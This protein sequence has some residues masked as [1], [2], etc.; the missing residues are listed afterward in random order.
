M[1]LVSVSDNGDT[2]EDRIGCCNLNLDSFSGGEHSG[3]E[4]RERLEKQTN[5][6]SNR[7]TAAADA[8]CELIAL[9]PKCHKFRYVDKD[10]R[11]RG[12]CQD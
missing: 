12:L 9:K 8:E 5:I 2:W 6:G 4:N 7:G 1:R 3:E 10:S 11:R